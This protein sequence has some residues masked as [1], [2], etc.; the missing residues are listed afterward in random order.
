M[1]AA[2]Y[3]G[4][5]AHTRY[6]PKH[7]SFKYP[8]FMWYL[9]LE[10]VDT[11]PNLGRWFSVSRWALSKFRRSDYLGSPERSLAAC[12]KDKMR[13][14]TGHEVT[15]KVFG[16]LNCSSL[17]LYFSPVN[18][19]YG[20]NQEGQAT[21]LLAEVSNI[22]WNERHFYA[23]H[24]DQPDNDYINQKA[25]KVS[26]FNPDKNQRYHWSIGAP[27]SELAISLGVHDER[28]HVFEASLAFKRQPFSVQS[29]RGLMLKKPVMTAFIVAGIYWQALHL[30]I[31]GIPFIP[32]QKEKA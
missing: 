2:I 8:F 29:A 11:L 1:N 24:L 17:G 13:L 30:F 10:R 7:H 27:G 28:G 32:Y 22:P 25:F 14:L 23:H 19:Y 15:G 21:H 26:P 4:S 6:L 5:I 20:F 18:F 3:S 31:K 9:D 16:L 12:V